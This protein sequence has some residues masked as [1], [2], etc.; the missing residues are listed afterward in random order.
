MWARMVVSL[1]E[2]EMLFTSPKSLCVCS[3]ERLL[4]QWLGPDQE[5]E[6]SFQLGKMLK[7]RIRPVFMSLQKKSIDHFT[8]CSWKTGIIEGIAL[9]LFCASS[10]FAFWGNLLRG[11]PPVWQV[12]WCYSQISLDPFSGIYAPTGRNLKECRSE[13]IQLPSENLLL[14]LT[15]PIYFRGCW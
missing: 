6:T 3:A 8:L 2:V 7:R 9:V 10:W 15:F 4:G 13:R 11:N 14:S 1:Q 12:P 5:K